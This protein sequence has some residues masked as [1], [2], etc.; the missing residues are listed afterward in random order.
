MNWSPCSDAK[1]RS[2]RRNHF[3][4]R[5]ARFCSPPQ[6]FWMLEQI[7]RSRALKSRQEASCLRLAPLLEEEGQVGLKKQA[8][9]Q[10]SPPAKFDCTGL[11]LTASPRLTAI[12]N[13]AITRAYARNS[14]RPD[15]RK[16]GLLGQANLQSLGAPISRARCSKRSVPRAVRVLCGYLV[17]HGTI[18]T[19]S[20]AE[21]L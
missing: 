4:G 5:F 7:A 12:R 21:N 3:A 6:T 8:Q 2:C 1:F 11:P 17:D 18:A 9:L 14:V 15:I 20:V 19:N 16:S 10:A 13:P